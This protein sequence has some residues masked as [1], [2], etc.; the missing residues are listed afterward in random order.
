[1][2]DEPTREETETPP[3]TATAVAERPDAGKLPQVV[4]ITD[5]GP[6][7]KHVKVTVDRKAIDGRFEDKFKELMRDASAQVNGFRPGKAPRKVIERRF[8]TSVSDQVRTEVLMASL[9]QLG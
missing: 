6:C 4:E 7:K 3:P 2:A 8:K 1:M 9:E 5:V